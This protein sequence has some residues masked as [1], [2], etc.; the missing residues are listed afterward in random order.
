MHIRPDPNQKNFFWHLLCPIFE[1]DMNTKIGQNVCD[2]HYLLG[3]VGDGCEEDA[4]QQEEEGH[5]EQEHVAVGGQHHA[6]DVHPAPSY[7]HQAP[8]YIYV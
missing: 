2:T 7:R 1:Y 3:S 4:A 8:R 6:V 5:D